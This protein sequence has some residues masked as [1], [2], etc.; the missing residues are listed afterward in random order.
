MTPDRFDTLVRAIKLASH[1]EAATALRGLARDSWKA[2]NVAGQEGM[3][4]RQAKQIQDVEDVP[5]EFSITPPTLNALLKK[6]VSCA[7]ALPI[8]DE[9]PEER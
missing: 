8:L 1:E 6:L 3:R 2:G 5:K 4:T 9:E 7:Q